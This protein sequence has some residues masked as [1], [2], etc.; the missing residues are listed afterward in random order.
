[1][2]DTSTPTAVLEA[3]RARLDALATDL[4]LQLDGTIDAIRAALD[5][6]AARVEGGTSPDGAAE[7]ADRYRAVLMDVLDDVAMLVPHAP[8]SC[9]PALAGIYYAVENAAGSDPDTLPL[10]PEP[11]QPAPPPSGLDVGPIRA[12]LA[13]ATP[14]PWGIQGAHMDYQIIARGPS[15]NGWSTGPVIVDVDVRGGRPTEKDAD[16]IAHAPADIAALL[17]ELDRRTPP[18]G[19]RVGERVTADDPDDDYPNCECADYCPHDGP[20]EFDT[21]AIDCDGGTDAG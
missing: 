10:P 15:V 8:A 1:M 20:W 3:A 16:F 17:A 14:G 2:S 13:A 5:L 21:E 7:R 19:P 18:P 12:R 4:D 11:A 6:L 9:W